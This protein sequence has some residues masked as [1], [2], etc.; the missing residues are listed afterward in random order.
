MAIFTLEDAARFSGRSPRELRLLI[1]KGQIPARR[2]A[3]RWTVTSHDLERALPPRGL[4][5][6]DAHAHPPVGADP[7]DPFAPSAPAEG[8][9]TR[10][11]DARLVERIRR[12]EHELTEVRT[13]LAQADARVIDLERAALG[14]SRVERKPQRGRKAS[15][16]R[17][18]AKP[19]RSNAARSDEEDAGSEPGGMR[20]A[21]TPLFKPESERPRNGGSRPKSSDG[22]D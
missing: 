10:D 6:P 12:L 8:D 3:G 13:E 5:D 11:R 7:D 20:Q 21:L 16:P 18:A 17:G 14:S 9:R 4:S 2:R 15:G 1:E 19:K 22:K